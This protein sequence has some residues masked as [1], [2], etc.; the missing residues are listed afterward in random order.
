M[1][2]GAFFAAG[3]IGAVL[4]VVLGG[5]ITARWGWQAAFGVVG[6]PGLLLA[7]LY[8][9]VP[10]YKTAALDTRPAHEQGQAKG[11]LAHM[12]SALTSS[13]TLWW[14]CLGAALQL[15]VVST[16]WAWLPSYFNRL[17]GTP[18]DQAAMQSALIVL[19]GAVGCFVWGI[20]ADVAGTKQPRNKLKTV[21]FLCMVTAP[22]L[23]VAFSAAESM[24]QQFL[25]IALGGFLMTCTVG[26][27]SSVV[28]DVVHPGLRSTGAALLSLFQNLFGL[29][30]GP[31]VGGA[32][33]DA[34][35]L[36]AALTAMPVFGLLAALCLLRASRTYERDLQEVAQI[37][38]AIAEQPAGAAASMT[39]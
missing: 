28:L 15:V 31:F 36:Q 27:A 24:N 34:F 22:I 4:G 1:L 9:F 25:L 39:A 32:L 11:L 7:L 33:S 14:T 12:V 6:V 26:P 29:A 2:L 20:V 18:V 30:I 16:I 21:S 13:R 23:V 38:S 8:M 10:D 19:C 5:V 37:Q 17:H 35:G 3:S